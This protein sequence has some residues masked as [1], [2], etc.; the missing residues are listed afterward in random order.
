MRTSL[1]RVSYKRLALTSP[2]LTCVGNSFAEVRLPGASWLAAALLLI[3]FLKNKPHGFPML[4]GAFLPAFFLLHLY[5]NGH[6]LKTIE[7][8]EQR[9]WEDD[10]CEKKGSPSLLF[11]GLWSLVAFNGQD[12]IGLLITTNRNTNNGLQGIT[13]SELQTRKAGRRSCLLFFFF[14]VQQ[15][16]FFLFFGALRSLPVWVFFFFSSELVY[17]AQVH[18]IGTRT[19]VSRTK[20]QTRLLFS[21]FFFFFSSIHRLFFFSLFSPPLRTKNTLTLTM[22]K[23]QFC[24]WSPIIYICVLLFLVSLTGLR[25]RRCCYNR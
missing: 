17:T 18:L 16:F 5:F 23:P 21:V 14:C 20:S 10:V 2:K 7:K 12:F 25:R 1:Y 3:T 15:V 8:G 22:L 11:Y 19:T 24:V 6:Q 13:F 9:R 4:I